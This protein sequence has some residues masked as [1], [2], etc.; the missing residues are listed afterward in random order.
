MKHQLSWSINPPISTLCIQR[1]RGQLRI[2]TNSM[3]LT[4][5][6]HLLFLVTSIL[7]ITYDEALKLA[8][9]DGLLHIT[10]KNYKQVIKNENFALIVFLTSED[11]RVGCTL[12]TE[13][14]P[15]YKAIAK[16][17]MQNLKDE[18][19]G[20]YNPIDSAEDKE[21]VIFAI[22]DYLEARSYF[23]RMQVTAVPKLLYYEPGNGPQLSE[24]NN[25]FSFLSVENTDSYTRWITGLVP[26]LELKYL[27]AQP[28]APKSAFIISILG[29]LTVLFG[30]F[31]YRKIA[32]NF[33]QNKNVWQFAS[34]TLIILF[35]SGY[36]Y[37]QIR[38]PD[39]YKI[40]NQ[41]KVHYVAVGHNLQYGSETQAL[42]VIYGLISAVLILLIRMVPTINKPTIKL[43]T[44]VACCIGSILLYSYIIEIYRIKSG[45]YPFHL[46]HVLS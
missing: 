21:R 45:S 28:P 12:C 5:L 22:S 18:L 6:S 30:L 14:G 29:F 34:L 13:F 33:L 37:N 19:S 39:F 31:K 15:K 17:Y 11:S 16:Q 41:G 44:S 1:Q 20:M 7:A 2:F 35:I 4:L 43:L 26:G 32:I 36:M 38:N 24:F 42:T 3:K 23:E 40:D 27:D 25:E 8:S 10:E 9:K 46:W